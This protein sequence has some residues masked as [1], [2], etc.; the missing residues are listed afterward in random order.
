MYLLHVIRTHTWACDV[1]LPPHGTAWDHC[2]FILNN[3]KFHD[4]M[5]PYHL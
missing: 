4:F 5:D 1:V 2:W 3:N